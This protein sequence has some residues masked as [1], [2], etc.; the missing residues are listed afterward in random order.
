MPSTAK[1]QKK[2]ATRGSH[3]LLNSSCRDPRAAPAAQRWKTCTARA[4]CPGGKKVVLYRPAYRH[5]VASQAGPD[6]DQEETLS[7]DKDEI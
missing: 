2:P 7:H 5:V 4:L 1:G 3:R 6:V